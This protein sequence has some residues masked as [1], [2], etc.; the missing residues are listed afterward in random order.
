MIKYVKYIGISN[1]ELTNGKVY[2]IRYIKEFGYGYLFEIIND[3]YDQVIYIFSF[4]KPNFEDVTLVYERNE[5]II[6]ILK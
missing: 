1:N 2:K 4:S 6:N 5:I 3:K